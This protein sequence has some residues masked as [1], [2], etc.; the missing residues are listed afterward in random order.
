MPEGDPTQDLTSGEGPTSDLTLDEKLNLILARLS[1]LEKK[2]DERFKD[3]RPIWEQA[4]AEIL[5]VKERVEMVDTKL[6][7]INDDILTLR[8]AEK[9]LAGRITKLE[10]ERA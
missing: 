2:M 6:S 3:T 5:E 1:A 7:A 10:G 4:L 9:R 8:A